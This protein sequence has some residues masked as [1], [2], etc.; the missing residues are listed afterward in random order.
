ME[1]TR[2]LSGQPLVYS[3]LGLYVT[4]GLDDDGQPYVQV[5]TEGMPA[6]YRYDEKTGLMGFAEP[7]SYEQAE[8]STTASVFGPDGSLVSTHHGKDGTSARLEA[9]DYVRYL[10]ENWHKRCGM[11]IISIHLNDAEVYD[12]RDHN[13]NLRDEANV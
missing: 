6:Q 12:A 9:R 10:N 2:L 11:P 13:S 7:Y 1:T 5:N 3:D 8:G 4:A